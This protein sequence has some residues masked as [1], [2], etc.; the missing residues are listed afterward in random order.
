MEHLRANGASDAQVMELA[1]EEMVGTGPQT[2]K[3]FVKLENPLKLGG[4]EEY[5]ETDYDPEDDYAE[6]TGKA[7]EF[8]E[9]LQEVASQYDETDRMEPSN[10]DDLKIEGGK[11]GEFIRAAQ[12]AYPY[13]TDPSTGELASAEIVRQTLEEMGYDG[14]IDAT[15]NRKFGTQSGRRSA[16]AGMGPE[17]VHVIAF[18]NK[19]VV[20]SATGNV[21][22]FDPKER[23][24]RLMPEESKPVSSKLSKRAAPGLSG[25]GALTQEVEEEA[26]D[27]AGMR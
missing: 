13:A 26:G 4:K 22:T 17:T 11:V 23:D 24:I 15:V 21:G 2:M 27:L 3:V 5:W 1:R 14:I 25:M 10:L 20:K 16:M 7:W 19:A 18:P 12:E 8:V 9:K 6:P